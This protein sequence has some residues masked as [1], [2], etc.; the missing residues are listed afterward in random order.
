MIRFHQSLHLVF[1]QI[2]HHRSNPSHSPRNWL[3]GF[4]EIHQTLLQPGRKPNEECCR[5]SSHGSSSDYADTIYSAAV[6]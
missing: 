1:V 4:S 2:D 5:A 3:I 6:R